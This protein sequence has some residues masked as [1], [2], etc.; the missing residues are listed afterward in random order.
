MPDLD[1][2]KVSYGHRERHAGNSKVPGVAVV[3]TRQSF[4]ESILRT[5][6]S[7]ATDRNWALYVVIVDQ[8]S[9]S[10]VNLEDQ[11]ASD[12]YRIVHSI[13]VDRIRLSISTIV[14]EMAEYCAVNDIRLVVIEDEAGARF[15]WPWQKSLSQRF[16]QSKDIPDTVVVKT[17]RQE[18][19]QGEQKASSDWMFLGL[20]LAIVCGQGILTYDALPE[21]FQLLI[22]VFAVAIIASRVGRVVSMVGSVLAAV[23]YVVFYKLIFP[24]SVGSMTSLW[25]SLVGLLAVCLI[26]STLS[27]Q[28]RS[29]LIEAQIQDRRKSAFFSLT[30]DLLLTSNLSEVAEL[31][32]H[33]LREVINASSVIYVLQEGDMRTLK[34]KDVILPDSEA[35]SKARDLAMYHGVEAGLGTQSCALA[36]R[37]YLPVHSSDRIKSCLGVSPVRQD[38][39]AFSSEDLRILD[40]YASLIGLTLERIQFEAAS[41]EAEQKVRETNLQ[42]TMLRSVSHDLKTPLT[43][44]TGFATQLAENPNLPLERRVAT[45]STIRDE[46]WRLTILIDNLLSITKLESQE[47]KP[48]LETMFVE[49]LIGTAIGQ[50]RQRLVDHDVSI[51]VPNDISDVVVDPMLMNQ[52][53]MNLVENAQKYTPEGTTIKVRA[54]ERDDRVVISIS[55]Q[56]PGIP[57]ESINRIFEKFVRFDQGRKVD[58]T[59][60]GLAIVKAIVELHEGAITV[61]NVEGGGA[62]FDLE[63]PSAR[64]SVVPRIVHEHSNQDISR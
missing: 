53:L 59:G 43:S 2:T 30:R 15:P 63:L 44:I 46:A 31:V 8:N 21:S 54:T 11:W 37:L 25:L 16:A 51:D 41:R 52:A 13:K 5:A 7:I 38:H 64:A 57:P 61:S 6:E 40:T 55:D 28:L 4:V 17:D 58:G 35:D 14:E 42:N 49:E 26:I 24:S 19:Q 50:V 9:D 1:S 33:H 45:Y 27:W 48:S 32:D 3:V 23:L 12:V 34:P 62:C 60:L 36:H 47:F 39:E 22:F 56:G 10:S 29:A 18:P 20:V